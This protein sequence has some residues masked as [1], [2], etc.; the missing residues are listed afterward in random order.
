M[1]TF[2][3]WPLH[4]LGGCG[5]SRCMTIN[6]TC[7]NAQNHKCFV[8]AVVAADDVI[9]VEEGCA[10]CADGLTLS[11]ELAIHVPNALQ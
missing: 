9:G 8:R 1:C 10:L 11:I 7:I 5:E 6:L 2:S 3:G 4:K